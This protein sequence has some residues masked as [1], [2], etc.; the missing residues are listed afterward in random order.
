[1]NGRE[2]LTLV[3]VILL[4]FCRVLI[5]KEDTA[6][7]I[8]LIQGDGPANTVTSAVFAPDGQTLYVG[9]WDKLV[10]VWKRNQAGQF[11]ADRAASF[12][13]P[14]GPGMEGVINSMDVSPDGRWL[15][16]GGR[17]VFRGSAGFRDHG[18]I[19]PV[20]AMTKEMR[21]D[22]GTIYVFDTR[23][24]ESFSLRGHLGEILSLRFADESDDLV[25]VSAGREYDNS[26]GKF[27]GV[28]RAWDVNRRKKLRNYLY[29]EEPKGRI[30]LA[31]MRSSRQLD[32]LQVAISLNSRSGKPAFHVWDVQANKFHSLPE[33]GCAV[34]VHQNRFVTASNYL[35][36]KIKRWNGTSRLQLA[37]ETPFA[38]QRSMHFVPFSLQPLAAQR[39]AVGGLGVK[40]VGNSMVAQVAELRVV[41][42]G[43]PE[44]RQHAVELWRTD[45]SVPRVPYVAVS[46]QGDQVAVVGGPDKS[47]LIFNTRDLDQG[48]DEPFQ[49]LRMNANRYQSADFVKGDGRGLQLVDED[50][51]KV[52]FDFEKGKITESTGWSADNSNVPI[53]GVSPVRD[54]NS[55]NGSQ[56]FDVQTA[57]SRLRFEMDRDSQLSKVAFSSAPQNGGLPLLAVASQSKGQPMLQ[58]HAASSGKPIRRLTG[59][60][61]RVRSLS[62]SADGKLLVSVGEEAAICVWDLRDLDKI[63]NQQGMISGLHLEDTAGGVRVI[64]VGSAERILAKGD[65]LLGFEKQSLVRI[66]SKADFFER[67]WA[68]SPGEKM[69]CRVRRSNTERKVTLTVDQGIDE[70]KPLFSLLVQPSDGDPE[71][72]RWIAWSPLGPFQSSDRQIERYVGWHFNGI[73]GRASSFAPLNQYREQFFRNDLINQLV[74][75]P[76]QLP[77]RPQPDPPALDLSIE[78]SISDKTAAANRVVPTTKIRS[79]L[80]VDPSFPMDLIDSISLRLDGKVQ[81]E[82]RTSSLGQWEHTLSSEALRDRKPHGLE[83]IVTTKETPSRRF[84]SQILV[85]MQPAAPIIQGITQTQVETS[86]AIYSVK[87]T[88]RPSATDQEFTTQ[89]LAA[90]NDSVVWE[91][92][93]KRPLTVNHDLELAEGE[94]RFVLLVRNSD[95]GTNSDMETAKVEFSIKRTAKPIVPPVTVVQSLGVRNEHTGQIE[96][97]TLAPGVLF[98][99]STREI[100]LNGYVSSSTD[101]E[102]KLDQGGNSPRISVT[103]YEVAGKF[104]KFAQPVTL[105]PGNQFLTL[106]VT[107]QN[108]TDWNWSHEVAFH[109]PVPEAIPLHPKEGVLI[110]TAIPDATLDFAA[111]LDAKSKGIDVAILVNDTRIEEKIEFT[112]VQ[113][114]SLVSAKIPLKIGSNSI[115][116]VT[117]NAWSQ[118]T[119]QPLVIQYAPT[120][121]ITKRE[122]KPSGEQASLHLEGQFL[123]SIDEITLDGQRIPRSQ[124]KT[125]ITE[126]GF[127]VDV[128][129]LP[130]S[131]KYLELVSSAGP[132]LKLELPLLDTEIDPSPPQIV[133]NGPRDVTVEHRKEYHAEFVIRSQYQLETID[134]LHQQHLLKH[135]VPAK[136]EKD[137]DGRFVYRRRVP[138]PLVPDVN[139]VIVSARSVGGEGLTRLRIS[140]IHR[141]VSIVIAGMSSTADGPV[142]LV[143]KQGNAGHVLF[144][145]AAAT[146]DMWLYGHVEWA[147]DDD[148][149]IHSR[150]SMVHVWVNGFQ[151]LP[152]RL[153][154]VSGGELRRAFKTRVVLGQKRA[155]LIQVVLPTLATAVSHRQQFYVDCQNP[156]VNRR[157]H[158]LALSVDQGSDQA[159]ELVDSGIRA[160][161]GQRSENSTESRVV[162]FE[163]SMGTGFVYTPLMAGQITRQ[164]VMRQIRAISSS[165]RAWN[166]KQPATDVVVVYYQ[167]AEMI[168]HQSGFYLTTLPTSDT[169]TADAIRH[170]VHL[171]HSSVSS[172]MLNRLVETNPGAYL[173]LLDVTRAESE[174][175]TAKRDWPNDSKAAMLR[176]A[177]FSNNSTPETAT[178]IFGLKKVVPE[179]HELG[180]LESALRA[181]QTALSA[182]YPK[183]LAFDGHLPDIL[184]SLRLDTAP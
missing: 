64:E 108:Q 67:V 122:L 78:N 41:G 104:K 120:P 109:P 147:N 10:W 100:I 115:R 148:V 183:S 21:A 55:S 46:S 85:R 75:D 114:G 152:V 89:I 39:L 13:I 139:E 27:R 77:P 19:L 68:T 141:P 112:D 144:D 159:N 88:I 30:G 80:D 47:I 90:K 178:L 128:E 71:R 97:H 96:R 58:I 157:V 169:K 137:T 81:G 121:Q 15:A 110:T 181:N 12:R 158:L 25:L 95:A 26:K 40:Q 145:R 51:R 29:V 42:W 8:L 136:H 92:Q 125:Q 33:T 73:N 153:E 165:V 123:D 23:S 154:P 60:T 184:R 116:V 22:Q 173:L 43:E 79:I 126:D 156:I 82:F 87:A 168:D 103:P 74:R 107:D 131:S 2:P 54:K 44:A 101:V 135:D 1:M 140:A 99:S 176:Y 70:R 69:V 32:A 180:H 86:E 84:A 175:R 172:E 160:L 138:I 106:I 9:G 14:M 94:N 133:L 151:Q 34:I 36:A 38:R 129:N 66:S 31:V 53:T 127:V 171:R 61:E 174:E 130:R 113:S 182:Q 132:P 167:G 59:H 179:A 166:Q 76:D 56:F 161:N 45:S 142:E 118:K 150:T 50:Q 20:S 49:T 63:V 143:A 124:F 37:G 72:H 98:T 4:G 155:N 18:K 6:E 5:A 111:K 48:K 146:G 16:V 149:R 35:P 93:A 102:I 177:W 62:F 83:A 105:R 163:S 162:Q 28:V 170:P 134:V 11:V 91:R 65:L 117:S 24:G 17:G 3:V 119:S 7:P 52:V 164:K 57:S